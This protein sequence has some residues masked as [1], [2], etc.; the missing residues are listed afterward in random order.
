MNIYLT[1][2]GLDTRYKNYMD[3]YE[4]IINVL[5]NKNVAI[6]PNAKLISQDRT[7]SNIAQEE[8][9]KNDI[10][11]K[12]IDLDKDNLNIE[13]YD[14]LYLSGGEPKNLM[15]SIIN[16]NNYEVI[17]EFIDN[18]GIVIGQSA[19]AMIFNKKYLDTTTGDLLT[20]GNGFNYYDRII[21]PHYNNLSSEL[22]D[23]IPDNILKINDNDKL[24]KLDV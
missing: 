9:I 19:G 16:S 4:D 24:Y 15:D 17:K 1:S 23:K 22:L 11:C 3:S 20:M 21:V 18:G 13:E 6:I 7:N 8:L 2:Y 14:A 12:I 10:K 5:R